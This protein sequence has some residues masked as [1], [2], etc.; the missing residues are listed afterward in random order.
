MTPWFARAVVML[1]WVLAHLELWL[2]SWLYL[3]AILQ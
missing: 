2:L 1:L 3:K